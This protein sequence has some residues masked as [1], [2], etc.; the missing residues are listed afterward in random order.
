VRVVLDTNVLVSAFVFPGGAPEHVY[1]RV[2]AGRVTLVVSQ[3][4]LEEL[5]RVLIDKFRWEAT[6][7]HEVLAQLLRV[8]QFVEP[9]DRVTD[10]REDPADN[11][12]LEAAAEG[13]ADV[14]VTGDRHLRRLETWRGVAI[15]EPAQ[16]L[17]ELDEMA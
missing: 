3:P 11:R 13:R 2:L 17:D 1:R 12:V 6:Y 7:T 5:A 10:I 8:G 9:R 4:L 15:L 14:I 16:L